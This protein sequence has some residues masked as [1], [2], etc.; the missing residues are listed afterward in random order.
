MECR[1]ER[2]IAYQAASSSDK[3]VLRRVVGWDS[4]RYL[5]IV[6][7]LGH[8]SKARPERGARPA[9]RPEAKHPRHHREQP[10]RNGPRVKLWLGLSAAKR[11]EK[12]GGRRRQSR[13]EGD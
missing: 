9:S 7:R 1:A 3:E 5:R 10:G 12:E 6:Q 4:P 13:Q 8:G 11:F 2:R